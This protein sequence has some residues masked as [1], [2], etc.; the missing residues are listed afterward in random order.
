MM[1][2]LHNVVGFNI[3]ESFVAAEVNFIS[4]GTPSFAWITVCTFIPP[5]FLPVFG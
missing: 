5:F 4:E 3:K 2:P 1:S